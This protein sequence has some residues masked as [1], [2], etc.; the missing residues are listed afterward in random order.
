MFGVTSVEID[1]SSVHISFEYK[2]NKEYLLPSFQKGRP[3][4][5][6]KLGNVRRPKTM[7]FNLFHNIVPN[8]E[9]LTLSAAFSSSCCNCSS[10]FRSLILFSCNRFFFKKHVLRTFLSDP[11][12]PFST[13]GNRLF[14]FLE[15]PSNKINIEDFFQKNS[16]FV[17]YY[18]VLHTI[19]D[20]HLVKSGK[21][22]LWTIVTTF[23]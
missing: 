10:K 21:S 15:I 6:G 7:L 9:K 11:C 4:P 5:C 18:L 19:F 1:C 22:Q 3:E 8:V 2:R 13:T 17:P 20:L 23:C 14:C 16:N 12:Q